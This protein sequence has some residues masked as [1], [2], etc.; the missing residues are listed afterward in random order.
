MSALEY[1]CINCTLMQKKRERSRRQAD[2]ITLMVLEL[3]P[4]LENYNLRAACPL[5]NTP[6]CLE[7]RRLQRASAT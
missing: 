1:P 3:F 2:M 5:R 4:A 6:A 7:E